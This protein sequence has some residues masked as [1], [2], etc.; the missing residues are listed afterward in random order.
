MRTL[1][2]ALVISLL[3]MSAMAAYNVGDAVSFTATD[4]NGTAINSVD[5]KGKI[6]VLEWTNYECPFVKKHYES[7][8]MQSLQKD[9]GGKDEVV[10]I[11]VNSSAE[12]KEGHLTAE[13]ARAALAEKGSAPDAMVLDAAGTLGHQFGAKTTPH[14]FVLDKEG[15]LAYMGAIDDNAS[16]DAAVIPSSRN[17]VREVVETLLKGDGVITPPTAPYGCSVKYMK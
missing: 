12:G 1:L 8:N 2:A 17:Y 6:V 3:P 14:M 13:A 16:P 15:K 10:W 11:A 4:I 9:L 5:Y 7:G